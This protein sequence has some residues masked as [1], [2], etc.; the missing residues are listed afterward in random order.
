M[1]DPCTA[2]HN[3]F[4]HDQNMHPVFTPASAERMNDAQFRQIPWFYRYQC[5]QDPGI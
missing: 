2:N 5:M 3:E 1:D 4:Y